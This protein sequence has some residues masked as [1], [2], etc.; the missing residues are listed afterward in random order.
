[1]GQF[2]LL[3]VVTGLILIYTF[4]S[5]LASELTEFLTTI[6]RWRAKHLQQS[7]MLLLGAIELRRN[8]EQFKNTITG[9]LYYGSLIASVAQRSRRRV[10]ISPS[11]LSSK[12]FA[13]AH[14]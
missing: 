2:P 11:Y 14:T 8:P 6:W 5:L 12:V 4:L 3:D 7:I 10:L 9:K 13:D 1:M